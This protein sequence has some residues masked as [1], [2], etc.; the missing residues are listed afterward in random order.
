M[1]RAGAWAQDDQYADEAGSGRKPTADSDALAQEQDRQRRDEQRRDEAG[2]R[3]FR[4]RQVN[5]APR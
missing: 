3:G 1:K 2:G 4:D 5:A